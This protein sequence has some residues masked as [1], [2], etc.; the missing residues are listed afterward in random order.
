MQNLYEAIWS[1]NMEVKYPNTWVHLI[2]SGELAKWSY[3][4]M[5][6]ELTLRLNCCDK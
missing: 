2:I 1:Y 3:M 5:G 6:A 4:E